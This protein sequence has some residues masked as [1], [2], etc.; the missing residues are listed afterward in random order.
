MSNRLRM[1][2][3]TSRLDDTG[4]SYLIEY[5]HHR[6]EQKIRNLNT[7]IL[8][9]GG[10]GTPPLFEWGELFNYSQDEAMEHPDDNEATHFNL[11][12]VY[13]VKKVNRYIRDRNEAVRRRRGVAFPDN[14]QFRRGLIPRIK[15]VAEVLF[16][17]LGPPPMDNILE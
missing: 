1:H 8:R 4:S 17:Y 5:M 3:I 7:Y 9:Q 12:C 13:M 10:Y 15:A 6:L 2:D 14:P 16:N 11:L